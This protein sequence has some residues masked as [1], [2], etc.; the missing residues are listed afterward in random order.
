MLEDQLQRLHS[1]WFEKIEISLAYYDHQI[2]RWFYGKDNQFDEDCINQFSN[3]LNIPNILNF[4]PTSPTSLLGLILLF[5]QIPRNSF[6][7]SK[8]AYQYDIQ[9]QNLVLKYL[10]SSFEESLTLPE[11]IFFYMPLQHSE[12]IEHQKISLAKFQA[13]HKKAPHQIRNWTE[14]GVRKA[15]EHYEEINKFGHFRGRKSQQGA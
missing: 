6:R 15:V 2:V 8:K 10:E 3:T 12:N 7:N 9:A 5:D 13:I 1:F 14:L 4:T 11:K